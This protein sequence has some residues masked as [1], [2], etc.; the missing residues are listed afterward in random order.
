MEIKRIY[1]YCKAYSI[2]TETALV[3]GF[4]LAERRLPLVQL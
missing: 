2:K 1:R 3:G 4:Y